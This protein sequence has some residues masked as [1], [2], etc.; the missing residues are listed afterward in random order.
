MEWSGN[1]VSS[2]FVCKQ[3]AISVFHYRPVFRIVLLL[4][5]HDCF[6]DHLHHWRLLLLLVESSMR[7]S[8]IAVI[9]GGG[10]YIRLHSCCC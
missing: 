4:L 8:M 10:R 5:A 7:G 6:H 2:I 9:Y 1:E 3:Q